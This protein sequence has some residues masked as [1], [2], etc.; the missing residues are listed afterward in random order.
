MI[1]KSS[2]LEEKYSEFFVFSSLLSLF[3]LEAEKKKKG[4]TGDRYFFGFPECFV[5]L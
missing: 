2:S 3:F 5:A 4:V 1:L